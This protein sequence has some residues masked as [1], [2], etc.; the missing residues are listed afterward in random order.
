MNYQKKYLK[1]KYKYLKL[2]KGSGYVCNP[3]EDKL[4]NFCKEVKEFGEYRNLDNCLTKCADKRQLYIKQKL[5]REH[6]LKQAPELKDLDIHTDILKEFINFKNQLNKELEMSDPNEMLLDFYKLPSKGK[7]LPNPIF[8]VNVS[9]KVNFTSNLIFNITKL[10]LKHIDFAPA[11]NDK[12][13]TK[14][15]YNDFK[16][17]ILEPVELFNEGYICHYATDKIGHNLIGDKIVS[18]LNNIKLSN[19]TYINEFTF[20]YFQ[21]GSFYFD[22]NNKEYEINSLI[23]EDYKLRGDRQIF[24]DD[25]VEKDELKMTIDSAK[26]HIVCK[27]NLKTFTIYNVIKYIA[28]QKYIFIKGKIL[29]TPYKP[30]TYFDDSE[31]TEIK[32]T[33]DWQTYLDNY[34]YAARGDIVFYYIETNNYKL[35]YN[36]DNLIDYFKKNNLD[37]I[38]SKKSNNLVYN[39]RLSKLIFYSLISQTK[40]PEEIRDNYINSRTKERAK[41]AAKR[42]STTLE[43]EKENLYYC[44]NSNIDMESAKRCIQNKWG[45][46]INDLCSKNYGNQEYTDNIYPRSKLYNSNYNEFGYYESK[47]YNL[48]SP[49]NFKVPL[50]SS[51]GDSFLFP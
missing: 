46:G 19:T 48:C 32:K 11:I 6:Y 30:D 45:L 9:V 44:D 42:Y 29:L 33:Y 47:E 21:F 16:S 26:S 34:G 10:K 39:K 31:V 40:V 5:A 14:Y 36:L 38:L 37:N 28:S 1:Y 2:Q 8:R 12:I 35:Q 23:P 22:I 41:K 13:K 50:K 7:S 15:Y 3:K 43:L 20:R 51:D 18:A 25:I 27:Y 17:I 4:K 24:K 49:R